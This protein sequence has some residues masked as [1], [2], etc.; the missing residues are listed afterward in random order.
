TVVQTML[1]LLLFQWV[2]GGSIRIPGL[3]YVDYLI[4]A[5]LCQIAIFDG[6]AV[7][8]GLAEDAKSGL[9]DRFRALPMARSAFVSGRAV[10]DLLRQ[11]ALLLIT[12]GMGLLL[13]FGFHNGVA[14]AIGAFFVALLFG[15][16]LFFVFAFVGLAT[17]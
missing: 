2:F 12:L 5:F 16:A 7:S 8:V 14:P 3:K 13:G 4:P 11:A 10:A 9:I 17:R 1:F 15:L 6:F